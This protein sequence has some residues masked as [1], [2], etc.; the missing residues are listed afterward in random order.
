MR[1][2]QVI[3]FHTMN[4][5]KRIKKTRARTMGNT[6]RFLSPTPFMAASSTIASSRVIV[7]RC[8]S[9][10]QTDAAAEWADAITKGKIYCGGQRTCNVKKGRLLLTTVQKKRQNFSN[11]F[12]VCLQE[13]F[14]FADPFFSVL[15]HPQPQFFPYSAAAPQ[16]LE[17]YM[18]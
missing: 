16:S 13:W 12:H 18:W 4:M 14:A 10:T 1:R 15:M 3:L 5:P 17:S 6:W 8:F 11:P 2:I 7:R 9:T